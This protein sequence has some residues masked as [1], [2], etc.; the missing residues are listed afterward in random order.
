MLLVEMAEPLL[1]RRR[2]VPLV[3][4]ALAG[5]GV[6]VGVVLQRSSSASAEATGPATVLA[7]NRFF[8]EKFGQRHV[9]RA[10]QFALSMLAACVSLCGEA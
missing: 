2:S 10:G 4:T 7:V 9:P 1:G 5:V 3:L 6:G 8:L